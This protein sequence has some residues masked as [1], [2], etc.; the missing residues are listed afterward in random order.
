MANTSTRTLR[1]LS[2]LQA[3]RYWTG[4]ELARRIKASAPRLRRGASTGWRELGYPVLAHRGVEGGYQLAAGA[5]LPPLVSTTT[6]CALA[7]VFQSSAQ[8]A[9]EGMS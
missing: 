5:A 2:L 6:A 4:A 8:G 1:L 9:G 7:L 3:R